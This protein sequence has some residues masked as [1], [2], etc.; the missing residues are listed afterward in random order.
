MIQLATPLPA[1][2][3]LTVNRVGRRATVTGHRATGCNSLQPAS[4]YK[5]NYYRLQQPIVMLYTALSLTI[6]KYF[7]HRQKT[8]SGT[9]FKYR[10]SL[11]EI[12]LL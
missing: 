2:M 5:T 4:L 10:I 12:R 8:N 3:T 6:K 7:S 9:T 1:I 11:V